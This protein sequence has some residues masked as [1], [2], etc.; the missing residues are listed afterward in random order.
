MS[1]LNTSIIKRAYA[2]PLA[3]AAAGTIGAGALG[4]GLMGHY[5]SDEENKIPATIL[6]SLGGATGAGAGAAVGAGAGIVNELLAANA[7]RKIGELAHRKA[8]LAEALNGATPIT[9]ATKRQLQREAA[10]AGRVVRKTT[11]PVMRFLARHPRL[12][13]ATSLG[14]VAA[15]IAAGGALGAKLGTEA[16]DAIA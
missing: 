6:G 5:D 3:A 8:R 9:H 13:A 12:R 7:E 14:L 11:S 2:G 15:P 4:G 16:G 10:E 1:Y